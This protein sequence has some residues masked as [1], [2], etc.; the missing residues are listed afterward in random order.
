MGVSSEGLCSLTGRPDIYG[1]GIRAAFYAQWLGTLFIE[2]ISEDDLSDMRF[3]SI[4]SSAAASISLVIGVACG[5]LQPLDIYFLLLFSMGFFLFLM[6]LHVWRVLT[7]CQKHLDPFLLTQEVHGTFYYLMTLT[8]LAANVSIGA[9]YHTI[10]LPHLHR[11]CRDVV[12]ML[13]R[14]NLENKGY[15]IIGSVFYIGVLI[16]I[17]G[18]IFLK[19]CCSP[20]SHSDSRHRRN[21]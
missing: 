8:I 11:D 10:F 5:A 12:F 15:I 1:V 16:S 18:F 7:R 4:F 14:T 13:G 6:P 19:S 9:W 2:Y 21:R 3:I 20:I 17:G